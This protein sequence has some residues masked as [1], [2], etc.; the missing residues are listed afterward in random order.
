MKFIILLPNQLFE[1]LIFI[2]ENLIFIDENLINNKENNTNKETNKETNKVEIIV[3]EHPLYFTKF[4]YHKMKL[5]MH[6]STMKFYYEYL[7]EK[8]KYLKQIHNIIFKYI[9]FDCNITKMFNKNDEIYIYN[10]LD[11][12]IMKYF[13]DIDCQL[14]IIDNPGHI[15]QIK[16]FEE[17]L[18]EKNP[19][20]HHSFY[21][22][23]RKKFNILMD[24]DKPI[25]NKWS[26][27]K[28]NRLPFPKNE[29]QNI[30]NIDRKNFKIDN[31]KNKDNSFNEYLSEA[32]IYI[33]KHFKNN[34]GSDNYYLPITFDQAKKHFKK[35]IKYKLDNFGPYEDAVHSDIIFGYHSVMS[36]IINIGLITP[37][38]IIKYIMNN[39]NKFKNIKLQSIEGYIRQLF[40]REFC[41]FVYLNKNKELE[42]GNFFNHKNKI[43]KTWYNGT[44]QL[45]PI[46]N[47]IQ[48][49]LNY[50]WSHHIERLMY[51]GNIFLLLQIHPKY[52]Y[53]W[54]MELF[55]D[56][57]PWV[58]SPNVYGMSQFS[59]GNI[60]M[61]R[62]YFSSTNYLFNLS[63]YKKISYPKIKLDNGK[64]KL[65]KGKN[66]LDN[67]KNKLDNGK[68]KLYN[69]YEWYEIWNSLYYNF[70]N[71]NS[72]FLSK[73][74]STAN[75]VLL[76][77]KKSK[78]EK[79][80]IINISKLF[81]KKYI[82]TQN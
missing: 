74:Y 7:I 20:I 29:E 48:K 17:Y 28:E 42:S 81:I 37:K 13:N 67:G 16:N 35:F 33:N 73:N 19:I 43:D 8:Y 59:A 71:N 38:Y 51:L 12:D 54:F 2:D 55:I 78:I 39:L 75:M 65:D 34:H 4:N 68:N 15:C 18:N 30:N 6:R 3:Y 25:D 1:N 50:G 45:G 5:V 22:W 80:Q 52:V 62:P 46:N 77:N 36:P 10:P 58:M 66:K 61:K 21:I 23:C 27:D 79:E 60:M 26:F 70:I 9:E 49:A 72:K 82:D 11:H 47:I 44:T 57:Y 64:I 56:A 40:W 41:I 32:K 53:K 14:H 63:N 76:W 24:K 31:K 69:E